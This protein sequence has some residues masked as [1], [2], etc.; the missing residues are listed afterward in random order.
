MKWSEVVGLVTR[1][2]FLFAIGG[3]VGIAIIMTA[4]SLSLYV[5]SG[6]SRLDLSRPGYESVRKDV[7]DRPEE[8]FNSDG[9]INKAALDEFDRLL[10]KRRA[11]LNGLGDFEDTS[12][13][14]ASLRL[15]P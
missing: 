13:D 11:N 5:T 1:H 6:T 14:D 4:V 12:L 9:P 7:Q 10:Q 15:T 3:V 8:T 2:R